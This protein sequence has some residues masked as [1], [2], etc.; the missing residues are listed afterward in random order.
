[1][2]TLIIVFD[3][4]YLSVIQELI[5][6]DTCLTLINVKKR[7]FINEIK[8]FDCNLYVDLYIEER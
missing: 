6:L 3:M 5:L 4:M 1:M 7:G 2:L 8:F